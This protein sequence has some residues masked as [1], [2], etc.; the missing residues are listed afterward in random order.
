M[1]RRYLLRASLVA[2]AVVWAATI[3]AAYR[4]VRLFETTPGAPARAPQWWPETS[5]LA[6]GNQDWTM[7]M[8]IHP[9]CSC[10][11]ASVQEL[12]AIVDKSPGL[13]PH[14]L[15]FR[16]SD[17]RKGWEQTEVVKAASRMR[18]AR[19][20]IDVD[21]REASLFGG[22][23]SGQ[24]L[25]YDRNG[26]LRFAGGITSLRGHAGINSGRVDVIEIVRSGL[27]N[28]AHPV[29][30]CAIASATEKEQR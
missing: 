23:T 9:H 3:G 4:A 20:K 21:G 24:T 6:R 16:P 26:K 19:V 29:F 12:Q 7:V 8:L 22:F 5:S 15:V 11:R 28:G 18:Q 25:L 27:G 30:G 2:A 1:N 17:F 13:R 14:V 10:S